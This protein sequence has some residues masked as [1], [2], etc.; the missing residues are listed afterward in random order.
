MDNKTIQE[1]RQ[2]VLGQRLVFTEV[3]SWLLLGFSVI[4]F[5][6]GDWRAV[7]YMAIIFYLTR[8]C[9][10]LLKDRKVLL[11]N[12]LDLLQKIEQMKLEK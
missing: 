12:N 11:L 6:L 4:H 8:I 10:S 1:L 5:I 3:L 7:F 2:K 9:L